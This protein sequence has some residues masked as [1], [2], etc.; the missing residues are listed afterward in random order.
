MLRLRHIDG[1][2]L[3][4]IGEYLHVDRST[5]VRV[6]GVI[7]ARLTQET[8]NQL[9]AAIKLQPAEVDSLIRAMGSD[10]NLSVGRLLDHVERRLSS[11]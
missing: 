5:V 3:D 10:L 1:L 9:A 4:D 8:R 11:R 6:L 7:R 2:G